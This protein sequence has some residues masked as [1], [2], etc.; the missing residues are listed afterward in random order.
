MRSQI[1]TPSLLALLLFAG[2]GGQKARPTPPPSAGPCP[3]DMIQVQPRPA[4]DSAPPPPP[5]CL[6]KAEVTVSMY[7]DCVGR[8]ACTALLPGRGCNREDL[9]TQTHPVNCVAFAEAEAFCKARKKRLPTDSEWVSAAA[10]TLVVPDGCWSGRSPRAGTCPVGTSDDGI[11]GLPANVAEWTS[12]VSPA[13]RPARLVRG[14]SYRS[15][16]PDDLGPSTATPTEED[17]RS[18]TIG[19]RCAK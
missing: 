13:I 14:G 17:V 16:D 8:A 10:S 5:F 7:A 6:D 1:A 9:Q 18:P 15:S 19:F 3:V 2:C 11:S 12:S 4:T